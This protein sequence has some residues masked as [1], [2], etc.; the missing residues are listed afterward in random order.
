MP[1]LCR[2][3]PTGHFAAVRRSCSRVSHLGY[4]RRGQGR[5][6]APRLPAPARTPGDGCGP[7]EA[8]QLCVPRI[9]ARAALLLRNLGRYTRIP[10]L[11]VRHPPG[12]L[13][14]TIPWWMVSSLA[15]GG[16]QS[17]RPPRDPRIQ[18][19]AITSTEQ[20]CGYRYPLCRPDHRCAAMP[21]LFPR[22]LCAVPGGLQPN[23][24][25]RTAHR[26]R[27]SAPFRGHD[28]E[29]TFLHF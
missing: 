27:S 16:V 22:S 19:L 26:H 4:P 12:Q 15:A 17:G 9:G 1:P 24:V 25:H 11:R 29:R 6:F 3:S 8:D 7:G 10:Q 13:H 14:T 5:G 23:I 2:S 20:L 21:E 18:P 28:P